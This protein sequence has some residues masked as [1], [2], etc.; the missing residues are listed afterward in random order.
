MPLIYNYFYIG[1]AYAKRRLP[2]GNLLPGNAKEP[3]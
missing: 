3:L 2:I 1:T